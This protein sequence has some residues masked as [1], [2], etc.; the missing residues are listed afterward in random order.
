M[1]TRLLVQAR[2][3]V[4]TMTAPGLVIQPV[5]GRVHPQTE[6]LVRELGRRGWAVM[7]AFGG[8]GID[9]VRSQL[10]SKA[11]LGQHE[12]WFWLDSDMVGH[13]DG[14]E[15]LLASAKEWQAPLMCA[16]SVCRGS[17]ELNVVRSHPGPLVLGEAGG[18]VE[19][20]KGAFAYSVSHRSLFERIAETLPEVD[21]TDD[22]TGDVYPGAPFFWPLVRCRTHY[23]EDYSMSLR[24]RDAGMRLY[25]DTR[26]RNWHA[27]EELLG[28]EHLNGASPMGEQG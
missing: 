10:A 12:W 8:I 15:Q 3:G 20:A 26:V 27:G 23:G 24:A 11:L 6:D 14:V 7:R 25:C 16:A 28:W 1:G 5:A 18:V 2:E 13:A 19:I 22:A 9:R 21:Y 4:G 17:H